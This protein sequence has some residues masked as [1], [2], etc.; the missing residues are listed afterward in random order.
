[1]IAAQTTENLLVRRPVPVLELDNV[2]KLYQGSPPVRALDRVNLTVTAGE[3]SAV[4]GPSGS[5]KSTLLH[6]W[7]PWTSPPAE[8]CGSPASTRRQ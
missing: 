5:G 4:V 6:L 2:S 8:P 3:L 7:A 1:M